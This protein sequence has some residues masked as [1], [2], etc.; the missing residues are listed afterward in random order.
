ML[1]SIF[2]SFYGELPSGEKADALINRNFGKDMLVDI[3]FDI[4]GVEYRIERG[5]KKNKFNLY[6][7]GVVS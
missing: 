2:Y 1:S 6:A 3:T 5:R 4:S 7:N